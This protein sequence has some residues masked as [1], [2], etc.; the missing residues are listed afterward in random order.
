MLIERH[1]PEM[2]VGYESILDWAME[3]WTSFQKL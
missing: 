1:N 3:N 2:I